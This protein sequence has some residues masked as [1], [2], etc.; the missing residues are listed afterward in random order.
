MKSN[1]MMMAAIAAVGMSLASCSSDNKKFVED[2]KPGKVH[3]RLVCGT[4]NDTER[5]YL[6]GVELSGVVLT[7]CT[8]SAL[9]ANPLYRLFTRLEAQVLKYADVPDGCWQS[10]QR[11]LCY[12]APVDADVKKG[13][14][15]Y[16]TGEYYSFTPHSTVTRAGM[17]TKYCIL[18]IRTKRTSEEERVDITVNDEWD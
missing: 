14:A 10:K 15:Q 7:D 16:G 17:K 5:F 18:P 11:I 6:Q 1:L 2:V 3:G 8:P 4:E 12:D 13:G 9:I